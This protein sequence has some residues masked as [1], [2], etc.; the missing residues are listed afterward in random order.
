MNRAERMLISEPLREL[1]L[2][3]TPEQLDVV[4][5][6]TNP[7]SLVLGLVAW[8]TRIYRTV[9]ARR[10]EEERAVLAEGEPEEKAEPLRPTPDSPQ[11]GAK[12]QKPVIRPA[13]PG[14]LRGVFE[15]VASG[16]V[17]VI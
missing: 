12:G 6:Y 14:D 1:F 10:A 13:Q 9:Q 8:F 4:G 17:P 15:E 3:M 11:L 5:K 16:P 2:D 7:A